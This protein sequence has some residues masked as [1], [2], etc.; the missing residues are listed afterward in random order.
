MASKRKPDLPADASDNDLLEIMPIGAGSE[1]GRSCIILKYK[2]KTI[3][4]NVN[5]IVCKLNARIH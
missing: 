3:M 5:N 2:G 1:V 4:V